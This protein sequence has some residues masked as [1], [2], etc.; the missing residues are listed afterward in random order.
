[1]KN[2][3]ECD[4]HT[5]LKEYAFLCV[6]CGPEGS[7]RYEYSNENAQVGLAWAKKLLKFDDITLNHAAHIIYAK[8][9]YAK[10]I[11]DN[12]YSNVHNFGDHIIAAKDLM[13]A[14]TYTYYFLA[15]LYANP[16]FG[17]YQNGKYFDVKKG[18]DYFGRVVMFANDPVIINSAKGIRKMLETKYSSMLR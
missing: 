16:V 4:Y 9:Y 14:D 11:D 18:Y 6:N 12:S 1:M 3:A 2:S 17:S 15:H 10:C 8:Y 13:P 5:A 7:F